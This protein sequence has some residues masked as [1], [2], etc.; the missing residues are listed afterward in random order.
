ML[1]EQQLGK[2]NKILT[3]RIGKT[4]ELYIDNSREMVYKLAYNDT[5]FT[6]IMRTFNN[7]VEQKIKLMDKVNAMLATTEYYTSAYL[8]IRSVDNV[9]ITNHI[10]A[11]YAD[12]F[13]TEPIEKAEFN[14]IVVSE[15]RITENTV[16][17][18]NVISISCKFPFYE[19]QYYGILVLNIDTN[20]LY[21]KILKSFEF[22]SNSSLYVT[23]LNAKVLISMD[24]KLLNKNIIVQ[25]EWENIQFDTKN[26]VSI[27]KSGSFISNYYSQKVNLRFIT[28]IS[29]GDRKN[30]LDNLMKYINISIILVILAL[31]IIYFSSSTVLMPLRKIA[32]KVSVNAKWGLK[33]EGELETISRYLDGIEI[34]N[35][36]LKSQLTEAIPIYREKVLYD[37]MVNRFYGL[38]EIIKKLSYFNISVGIK[39]Y[40]VLTILMDFSEMDEQAINIYRISIKNIAQNTSRQYFKIFCI[41]AEKDK[42]SIA[43]N[44]DED[45][46]NIEKYDVIVSYAENLVNIIS[47]ELKVKITTGIGSFVESIENLSSS[48]QESMEALNYRKISEKSTISIYEVKRF[49]K[50]IYVYPY[51]VE[52]QLLNFVKIGYYDE[53]C[54]CLDKIFSDIKLNKHLRDN[55]MEYI[56]LQLLNS[57]NR[58]IHENQI[59]ID[60]NNFMGNFVMLSKNSSV[61][62]IEEVLK[63]FIRK[64]IEKNSI[65]SKNLSDGVADRLVK[66]INEHYTKALQLIDLT[67]K[68]DLNRIYVGQIIKNYTGKNFN[69]YLNEKRIE[70]AKELL[71]STT[72]SIKLIS[73]EVGFTYADYFIKIFKKYEGVT[74]GEYKKSR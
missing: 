38:E 50:N 65:S 64:I 44:I 69:D 58:L 67:E 29:V 34:E 55:E 71:K 45:T 43:V 6:Q 60:N 33:S 25:K 42:I 30:I 53:C 2:F 51:D 12:F 16:P 72:M 13:D 56:I 23:D 36:E 70:K 46:Q 54:N 17:K 73:E 61:E 5:E 20:K 15:P 8:Y 52:R 28:D 47:S 68:F 35:D 63:A 74:P 24:E 37:I 31:V 48:Y 41:D 9:L 11:K 22:G 19:E 40:V 59:Q 21:N 14:Q 3:E 1:Y 27:Q 32:T 39:N 26:D 57:L 62:S 10:S 18:Q 66:Y 49:N 4:Y 7:S